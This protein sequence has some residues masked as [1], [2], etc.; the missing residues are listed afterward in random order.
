[1]YVLYVDY[2]R[3]ASKH[4]NERRW[5]EACRDRCY[6]LSQHAP[7]TSA[8]YDRGRKFRDYRTLESLLEYV[9]VDPERRLIEVFRRS[10][11][12]WTLHAC[13][14]AD[15]MPLASVALDLP[16]A[17]AFADVDSVRGVLK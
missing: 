10:G 11:E 15:T 5:R 1:M 14:A 13:G 9:L 17:E 2:I 4:A 3:T 6:D 16:G 7:W 8:A 12:E